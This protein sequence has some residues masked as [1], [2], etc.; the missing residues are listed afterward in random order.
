[1]DLSLLATALSWNAATI[2]ECEV[3]GRRRPMIGNRAAYVGPTDLFECKDGSVFIACIM[4]TMWRRLARILGRGDLIADPELDHDYARYDHR[5]RIDPLVA[6]WCSERT[7]DEVMETMQSARIPCGPVMEL[8]EVAADPHVL[9]TRMLEHSDLE[10]PGLE[11]VPIGGL[12]VRMSR[13]PG[14]VTHR[15]PRV[16]EHNDDVYGG[17]LGYDET[18]RAEMAAAGII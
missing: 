17:L 14:A 8:D 1:V 4:N 16:G 3:L 13:T 11:R 6:D 5:D 10:T 12:P 18:Q 9:G 2:A 15:A 7:V